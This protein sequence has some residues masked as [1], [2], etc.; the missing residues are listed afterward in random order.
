MHRYSARRAFTLI[1]VLVA[2]ALMGVAGAGLAG[3][4]TADRRL[5]DFAAVHAFAAD[6]T[7][8]RLGLLAVLPC[9]SDAA[10]VT[11]SAWGSERWR[12]TPSRSIWWLTDS[13]ELHWLATPLVIKARVACPD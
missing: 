12:A 13:L 4:L 8:E 5:R 9:L 7:R 2:L 6:R 3:T 11:A 1:E 10:G